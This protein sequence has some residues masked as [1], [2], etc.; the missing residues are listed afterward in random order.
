M[1]ISVDNSRTCVALDFAEGRAA[2]LGTQYAGEM[3]KGLFSTMHYLMPDQGVLS[4]HS[5]A[6]EGKDGDV[7]L[8]FGLSGTGKTTLSHDPHRSLIGDD[9]TLWT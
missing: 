7:T 5:S 6:T 2:I 1:L 9:E 3:K 4:L 8:M